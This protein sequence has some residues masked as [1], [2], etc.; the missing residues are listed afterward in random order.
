MLKKLLLMAAVVFAVSGLGGVASATV[1]Q[2]E[3]PVAVHK[4][5]ICHATNA[6]KNPYVR[7]EVDADAADGDTGTDNGQGDHTT[8][9]GPVA[10]SEALAQSL[11]DDKQDWGDIIP[12]HDSYAAG[13]NWTTVGQAVYNNGCNYATPGR[14]GE[15]PVTTTTTTPTTPVATN[16]AAVLPSTGG[17]EAVAA[18][19]V[20]A[21]GLTGL[22][23]TSFVTT[24]LASRF[25][26]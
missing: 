18:L 9:T 4:V 10:S 3:E 24:R 26:K 20:A 6:V 21:I 5:T 1:V 13:L 11:K 25:V 2:E 7:I 14:G 15:T 22:L 19:S 8:H 17:G 12:P 16:R 23:G